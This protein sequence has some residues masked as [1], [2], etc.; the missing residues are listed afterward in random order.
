MRYRYPQ[1]G[2]QEDKHMGTNLN[3]KENRLMKSVKKLFSYLHVARA[4]LDDG[5]LVY[6][7]FSCDEKNRRAKGHVVAAGEESIFYSLNRKKK[8]IEWFRGDF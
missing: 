7:T 3:R 8:P 1:H 6:S 5:C 4:A 2:N